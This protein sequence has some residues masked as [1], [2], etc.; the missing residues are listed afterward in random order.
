[1]QQS[2]IGVSDKVTALGRFEAVRV[3][4]LH[5]VAL[6]PT[7]IIE[8]YDAHCDLRGYEEAL[9][10]AFDKRG[11]PSSEYHDPVSPLVFG[12]Y[13]VHTTC[14][15]RTTVILSRQDPYPYD[16]ARDGNGCPPYRWAVALHR[17]TEWEG[18]VRDHLLEWI[19]SPAFDDAWA[20]NTL[21]ASSAEWLD[22]I[23]SEFHYRGME[24]YFSVPGTVTPAEVQSPWPR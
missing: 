19:M 14:T 3:A 1:M 15:G 7:E 11:A 21:H 10:A 12:E 8:A 6:D 20:M 23:P 17:T 4:L 24:H 13:A 18:T 22:I 16:A 2:M 5:Q 9:D